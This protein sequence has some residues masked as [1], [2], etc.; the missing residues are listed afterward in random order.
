MVFTRRMRIFGEDLTEP[1]AQGIQIR[2]RVHARGDKEKSVPGVLVRLKESGA[3]MTTDAEG[4]FAFRVL[5]GKS[6]V[7][8]VAP[9]GTEVSREIEVPSPE[10]D[11][12]V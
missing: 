3:T 6:H 4:R 2:G 8:V 9:D 10:Y 7:S 12:Q 5:E 11:L 1:A